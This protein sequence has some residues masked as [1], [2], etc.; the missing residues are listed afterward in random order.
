[1]ILFTSFQNSEDTKVEILSYITKLLFN[2][3]VQVKRWCY[4]LICFEISKENGNA[5]DD[6]LYNLHIL[7]ISL[8]FT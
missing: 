2:N 7:Y 6:L 1:M 4:C 3:S 5:G 8:P